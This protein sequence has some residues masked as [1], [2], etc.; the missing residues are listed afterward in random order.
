LRR[1]LS[2]PFAKKRKDR[3]RASFEVGL[4]F[5]VILFII[6]TKEFRNLKM[7]GLNS[8]GNERIP[9]FDNPFILDEVIG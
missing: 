6:I 1:G 7:G 5:G 8:P 4:T 2:K 3:E 9:Q